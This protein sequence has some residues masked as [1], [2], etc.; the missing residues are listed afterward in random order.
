MGKDTYVKVGKGI[1]EQIEHVDKIEPPTQEECY[2]LLK[3]NS[4][5]ELKIKFDFDYIL[6]ENQKLFVKES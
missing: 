5:N 3:Y 1:L 2:A 4:V 6:K